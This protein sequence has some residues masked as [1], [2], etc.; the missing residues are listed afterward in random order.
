MDQEN[1]IHSTDFTV[2][3]PKDMWRFK[4]F[5]NGTLEDLQKHYRNHPEMEPK[6]GEIWLVDKIHV[7]KITN[8]KIVMKGRNVAIHNGTDWELIYDDPVPSWVITAKTTDGKT[9]VIGEFYSSSKAISAFENCYS[10]EY[11]EVNLTYKQVS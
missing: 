3:F 6:T 4:D 2:S 5:F 1:D 8:E 11:A 7:S 10:A 9:I